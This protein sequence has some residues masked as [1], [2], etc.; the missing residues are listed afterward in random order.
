MK[1]LFC[2]LLVLLFITSAS[3]EAPAYTGFA[4]L[5]IGEPQF[6]IDIGDEKVVYLPLDDLGR[7]TGVSAMLEFSSIQLRSV[8]SSIK[9]TGWQQESYS[10]IS[11]LNLYNRCHMLAHQLGGEEIPENLFTGTQYINY[12]GMKPIEDTVTDY[13]RRTMHHVRYEVVPYFFGDNLICAGVTISA[14]SVEDDFI[15]IYEF[16]YNVQPGVAIDYSNGYSKLAEISATIEA[17]QFAQSMPEEE[18][19]RGITYVLNTNRK[20]FHLPGCPSIEETKEKN[21]ANFYGTR[22][23]LIDMGYTPCGRCNP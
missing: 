5:T 10:F 1:K 23:E 6:M 7:V 2:A 9:P 3:A 15:S 17:P 14:K 16:C 22:E 4:R 18:D 19:E 8:I 11:G 12:A 13:I 20:R 21:R